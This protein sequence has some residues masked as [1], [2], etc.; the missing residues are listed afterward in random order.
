MEPRQIA[1]EFLG[2]YVERGT[3][4]AYIKKRVLGAY[5]DGNRVQVGGIVWDGERPERLSRKQV[6]VLEIGGEPCLHIY[7]LPE[8]Y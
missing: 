4:L 8:L 6:A 1:L 2:P 5:A 3:T 7:S